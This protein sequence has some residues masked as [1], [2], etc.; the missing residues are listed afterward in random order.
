MN[1]A[2]ITSSIRLLLL[3][4]MGTGGL[5][6][7]PL[8]FDTTPLGEKDRPLILRTYVPDP[9]LP[10]G[11]LTNHGKASKSP[12]YNPSQGRDVKGEYGMMKVIPAA[13]AVNHGP[14]LSYVWDTTECR[15]LYAWQG[16]F[17][18]MYPYWGAEGQG[19]RR[20]F[21]YG[22]R[23]IGN[24]FYLAEPEERAKP[25][26]VGYDLSKT[27]VPT[28]HYKLGEQKFSQTI[29][30]ADGQFAFQITTNGKSETVKGKLISKHQGFERDLKIKDV[31]AKAGEKVF[32]AYG[33]VACHSVDGS[34]GHGPSLK[35]LAGS[36]RPIEGDGPILADASYLRE[37]IQKPN[38]KTAKGFPPGYMP[39]YQLKDKEVESLVLY[40]QSLSK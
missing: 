23:L 30:P 6:G 22:S 38:A 10:P 37:S 24:L 9:G 18:D 14:S 11:V 27:G 12:K 7:N 29:S 1:A 35:G 34:K 32:G 16:G 4:L 20:S 36:T 8:T 31:S 25:T 2:S 26:F 17:L 39:P 33:C 40:I 21:D 19:G 13:I 3:G 28:F 15:L 5:F